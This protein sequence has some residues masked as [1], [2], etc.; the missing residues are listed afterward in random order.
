MIKY[1]YYSQ[2]D[3][4]SALARERKHAVKIPR[5]LV[6]T[7]AIQRNMS[8]GITHHVDFSPY[9]DIHYLS[10]YGSRDR[11]ADRDHAL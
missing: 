9:A 7:I 5:R 3:W 4:Q 1:Q 6:V 2:N 11:D 10:G 8:S